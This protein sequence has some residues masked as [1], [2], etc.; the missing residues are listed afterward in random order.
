MEDSS[1]EVPVE[2]AQDLPLNEPQVED[3]LP[4]D[5]PVEES[6]APS[7]TGPATNFENHD[8]IDPS[9][10][11]EMSKEPARES[12]SSVN[13][14]SNTSEKVFFDEKTMGV[15]FVK[16]NDTLSGISHKIYGRSARWQM[17]LELNGMGNPK[18]LKA[19]QLIYYTYKGAKKDF[20][21]NQF[22]SKKGSKEHIVTKRETLSQIAKKYF[23]EES[24]WTLL[25]FYNKK[26]LANPNNLFVGQKLKI[27][28]GSLAE[29]SEISE[30]PVE[31]SSKVPNN[32][33]NKEVK[34][35]EKVDNK[36]PPRVGESI[37]ERPKPKPASDT[38]IDA[39]EY[40]EPSG[41]LEEGDD[42]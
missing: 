15:Y 27:P 9:F 11:Q 16:S 2:A 3:P 38:E 26:R 39:S 7:M 22:S 1:S 42:F 13:E 35:K 4:P 31:R 28:G 12:F 14:P 20:K 21:S 34:I 6:F 8:A 36:E 23:G 17:L 30:E 10:D 29:D 32:V 19:G 41:P 18:S 24:Y 5:Q 33:K 25:W 37:Y 40:I